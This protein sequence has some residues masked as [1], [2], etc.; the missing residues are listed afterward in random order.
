VSALPFLFIRVIWDAH[1]IKVPFRLWGANVKELHLGL[2]PNH[3]FG[4]K[5]LALEQAW[6]QL[7]PPDCRGMLILDG[8]TLIDP[9]DY[10]LMCEAI[11]SFPG[12]VHVAPARIWPSSKPEL[13]GWSWAH[14]SK[15]PTQELETEGIEFFSFNFTYLPARLILASVKGGLKGWQFPLVDARVS[16]TARLNRIPV[17]VVTGAAPKH[18]NY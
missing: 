7:A 6:Q 15:G 18:L 1:T 16:R 14:W 12:D 3:P 10:A 8:D 11:E 9:Q 4:R 13:R 17:H 2:D 5:G